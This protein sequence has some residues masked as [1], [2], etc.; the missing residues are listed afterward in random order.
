MPPCISRKPVERL[1]PEAMYMPPL[2]GKTWPVVKPNS[3]GSWIAHTE[4]ASSSGS[5]MR[6][7]RVPRA[8]AATPSSPIASSIG[9]FTG[10]GAIALTRAR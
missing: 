3:R 4:A 9:V 7:T 5:A 2:H 6:P 1:P 8:I 10:P